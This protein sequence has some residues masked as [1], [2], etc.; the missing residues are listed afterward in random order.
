M[1]Y[2]PNLIKRIDEFYKLAAP[3][4]T[5][6]TSPEEDEDVGDTNL[7]LYSM[8]VDKARDIE[9]GNVR[10]DVLLI[11]ELYKKALEMNAGFSTLEALNSNL[12]S[13]LNCDTD[14]EQDA[15]EELLLDIGKDVRKRAQQSGN[16]KDNED[17]L[18]ALQAVKNNFEDNEEPPED[19]PTGLEKFDERAKEVFDPTA[20]LSGERGLVDRGGDKSVNRGNRL[21]VKR[22]PK[23]WLELFQ[24]EK[25]QAERDLSDPELN[26]L[27][28]QPGSQRREIERNSKEIRKNNL[29]ELI[30]TLTSLSDVTFKLL[31]VQDKIQEAPD[32]EQLKKLLPTLEEQEDAL[33][34]EKNFT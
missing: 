4:Y 13:G 19:E 12:L 3:P 33:G 32:D 29:K 22:S 18:R 34:K 9:T 10:N 15:V 28:T 1:T 25:Q 26:I 2:L 17:V 21:I 27:R 5:T 30:T 14:E 31:K 11:A 23:D 24:A 16:A 8:I 20:G 6:Y 7:G